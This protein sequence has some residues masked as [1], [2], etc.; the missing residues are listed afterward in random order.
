MTS[1]LTSLEIQPIEER[2]TLPGDLP[3]DDGWWAEI[4]PEMTPKDATPPAPSLSKKTPE[5]LEP[6]G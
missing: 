5:P 1:R 6:E 2:I 3:K 4:Y